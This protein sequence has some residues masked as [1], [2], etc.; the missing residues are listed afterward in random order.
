MAFI[1]IVLRGEQTDQELMSYLDSIANTAPYAD[2]QSVYSDNK[3]LAVLHNTRS[4]I[5][6]IY[7]IS[8]QSQNPALKA[9]E[10]KL[11]ELLKELG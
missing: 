10:L 9:I 4:L 8:G 3:G 7:V 1:Y 5:N 2:W 6:S 11:A